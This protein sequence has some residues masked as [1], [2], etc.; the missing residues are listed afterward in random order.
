MSITNTKVALA[1]VRDSLLS[2]DSWS[3]YEVHFSFGDSQATGQNIDTAYDASLDDA[4]YRIVEM[5][6]G[7]TR[8]GRIVPPDGDLMPAVEP[9]QQDQD[10]SRDIGPLL[11]YLR[12]RM[13]L[14]PGIKKIFVVGAAVSGSAL[15]TNNT[16]T[17]THWEPGEAAYN[18]LVADVNAIL[19]KYPEARPVSA[20]VSLGTVDATAIAESQP[21]DNPRYDEKACLALFRSLF[22]SLRS[23]ITEG[24]NLSFAIVGM[25]T[26]FMSALPRYSK[27]KDIHRQ[28]AQED[29]K[30][31]LIET[32]DL[33]RSDNFHFD[34]KGYRKIG[35]RAA[36]QLAPVVSVP[37]KAV[38]HRFRYDPY[39]GEWGDVW[40][41][42]AS[43]VSPAFVR[44]SERGVVL[45]V[46]GTGFQTTARLDA[47]KE[48]TISLKIRPTTTAGNRNLVSY[49]APDPDESIGQSFSL[50]LPVATSTSLLHEA[51]DVAGPSNT[52][53]SLAN[54]G[55]G[56]V[57]TWQTVGVTWKAGVGAT[58]YFNGVAVAGDIGADIVPAIPG[59]ERRL[60]FGGWDADNLSDNAF[61]GQMDDIVILDRALSA[62]GMARLHWG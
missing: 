35:Q 57:N 23:D 11:P 22:S 48:Y 18:S 32:S 42:G 46:S 62:D 17:S 14:F 26:W 3:E 39:I 9:M 29:D 33:D 7:N 51:F 37:Y 34:G 31:V 5:S 55:A 40:G 49:K 50:G 4:S 1:A 30:I 41:R 56:T 19:A 10:G 16:G 15:S 36:I 45:D 47:T 20:L 60:H 28:L 24:S 12:R 25:P 53:N 54:N 38:R 2:T 61:T 27:I 44:D 21:T 59:G 13:Q 43:V 52:L 58:L 8:T 6:Q